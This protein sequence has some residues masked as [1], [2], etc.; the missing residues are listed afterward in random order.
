MS[1]VE[2]KASQYSGEL[3]DFESLKRF[4][5]KPR[6]WQIFSTSFSPTRAAE[7]TSLNN[8]NNSSYSNT[9]KYADRSTQTVEC[10]ECVATDKPP[11]SKDELVTAETQTDF[12]NLHSDSICCL[13]SI[14]YADMTNSP[15]TPPP[16]P[17]RRI[18]KVTENCIENHRDDNHAEMNPLSARN[19]QYTIDTSIGAA[20]Q[21]ALAAVASGLHDNNGDVPCKLSENGNGN[22]NCDNL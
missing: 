21:T 4:W 15:P 7:N 17:Y 19:L 18:N 12:T 11:V 13:S 16:V 2:A 3:T 9:V 8:N 5:N 14:P 10:D 22:V 6:L 1:I 20:T